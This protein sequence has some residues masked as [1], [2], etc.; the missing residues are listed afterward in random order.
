MCKMLKSEAN[1]KCNITISYYQNESMCC[2]LT[3]LRVRAL[4]VRI[5]K[6]GQCLIDTSPWVTPV[7]HL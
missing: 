3:S 1:L 4:E 6:D 7:I 2:F 5:W